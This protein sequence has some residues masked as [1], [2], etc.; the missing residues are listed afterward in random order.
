MA[1]HYESRNSDKIIINDF[2]YTVMTA[3]PY[4]NF[5]ILIVIKIRPDFRSNILGS[6]TLAIRIV[7]KVEFFTC[8]EIIF[9]EFFRF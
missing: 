9:K 7:N 1:I 3:L 8:V 2:C 5:R 6:K 4:T